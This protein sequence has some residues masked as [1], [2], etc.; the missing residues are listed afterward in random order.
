MGNS[1]W[2]DAYLLF[3]LNLQCHEWV[4]LCNDWHLLK[5][6]EITFHLHNFKINHLNIV[7]CPVSYQKLIRIWKYQ[8]IA[9]SW[10]V[11]LYLIICLWFNIELIFFFI[12]FFFSLLISIKL[13]WTTLCLLF[14]NKYF[15]FIHLYRFCTGQISLNFLV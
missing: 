8:L 13:Q 1:K 6:S 12:L 9:S 5:I 7:A 14:Q 11:V 4:L 3:Y 15:E 2:I 10:C